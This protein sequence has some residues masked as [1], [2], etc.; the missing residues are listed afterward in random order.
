M[1]SRVWLVDG[2]CDQCCLA[3]GNLSSSLTTDV[4]MPEEEDVYEL[5]G[6]IQGMS[7]RGRM[8]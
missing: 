1:L 2:L 8:S 3:V 4:Q 5:V 7:V 6:E